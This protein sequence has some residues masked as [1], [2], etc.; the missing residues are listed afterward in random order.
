MLRFA[1]RTLSLSEVR[2]SAYDGASSRFFSFN[3]HIRCRRVQFQCIID[4]IRRS[5]ERKNKDFVSA[6]YSRQMI[7][8]HSRIF[9][10]TGGFNCSAN[11]RPPPP[12]IFFFSINENKRVLLSQIRFENYFLS[13]T[14][15]PFDKLPSPH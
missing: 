13:M 2:F 8:L 12:D 3:Y 1:Y 9:Y 15:A 7:V 11:H 5:Y 6:F 4:E 10:I 14:A